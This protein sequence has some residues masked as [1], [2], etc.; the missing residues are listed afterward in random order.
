[1]ETHLRIKILR[2]KAM[3]WKSSMKSKSGRLFKPL[4]SKYFLEKAQFCN[5]KI[6]Y[7]TFIA[8]LH[9]AQKSP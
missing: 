3:A 2:R 8:G 1:M 6:Y 7:K 9:E 5:G 4:N